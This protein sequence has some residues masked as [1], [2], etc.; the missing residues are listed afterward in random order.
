MPDYVQMEMKLPPE[1]VAT[2]KGIGRRRDLMVAAWPIN[3]SRN[4]W[5]P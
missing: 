2:G 3:E 5:N 1:F 4:R